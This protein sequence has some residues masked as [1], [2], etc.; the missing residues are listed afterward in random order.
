MLRTTQSI[1]KGTKGPSTRNDTVL[2]LLNTKQPKLLGTRR[3]VFV[4]VCVLLGLVVSQ[5]SKSSSM[6]ASVHESQSDA[7]TRT[8]STTASTALVVQKE[9]N[10]TGTGTPLQLKNVQLDISALETPEVEEGVD[11]VAKTNKQTNKLTN[12]RLLP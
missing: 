4:M 10:P 2:G 6:I 5:V 3:N 8:P 7:S 1:S 11:A 12:K 9:A